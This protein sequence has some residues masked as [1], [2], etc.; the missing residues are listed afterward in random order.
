M[1]HIS[2]DKCMCYN[3]VMKKVWVDP[4]YLKRFITYAMSGKGTDPA[5]HY[6]K[7][8]GFL[9]DYEPYNDEYFTLPGAYILFAIPIYYCKAQYE[10]CDG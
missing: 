4:N 7:T 3:I 8:K 2:C 6:K 1:M 10:C 5:L 9:A